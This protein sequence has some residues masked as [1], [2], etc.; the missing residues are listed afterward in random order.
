MKAKNNKNKNNTKISNILKQYVADFDYD[1]D[2][3]YIKDIVRNT[4][5]RKYNIVRG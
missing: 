4:K 2:K 5:A 1:F 3:I